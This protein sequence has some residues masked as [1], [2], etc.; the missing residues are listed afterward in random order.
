MPNYKVVNADQL[1][2]DL[3]TVADAIR[4]KAGYGA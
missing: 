4:A 1:D 2:A 3:T